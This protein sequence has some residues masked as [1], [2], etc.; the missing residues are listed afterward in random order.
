M[1]AKSFTP[2]DAYL[3]IMQGAQY[4]LTWRAAARRLIAYL[5]VRFGAA[6]LDA[7]PELLEGYLP[8]NWQYMAHHELVT[9]LD[10]QGITLEHCILT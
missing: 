7:S 3:L 6:W 9:Y 10:V 1:H 5:A 4:H 8:T 2:D